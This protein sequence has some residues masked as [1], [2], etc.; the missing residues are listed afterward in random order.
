MG[1]SPAIPMAILCPTG[2]VPLQCWVPQSPRAVHLLLQGP[3][4]WGVTLLPCHPMD[5][6]TLGGVV[7]G[8]ATL[9][10]AVALRPS[11]VFFFHPFY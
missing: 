6:A 11:R 10:G 5:T 1:I 8:K 4:H 2:A 3:Q 9:G 7:P